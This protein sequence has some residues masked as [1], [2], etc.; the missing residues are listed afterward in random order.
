MER[1]AYHSP[2]PLVMQVSVD[3]GADEEEGET[4]FHSD[5]AAQED[6]LGQ[7]QNFPLLKPSHR[8][9]PVTTLAPERVEEERAAMAKM[10]AGRAH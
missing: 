2:F 5:V 7:N 8:G 1:K 6:L 4:V 9:Q 3:R 10:E